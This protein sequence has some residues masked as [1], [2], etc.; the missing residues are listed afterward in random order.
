M[1][2]V[3]TSLRMVSIYPAGA[4]KPISI[5]RTEKAVSDA[6]RARVSEDV[7]AAA[8]LRELNMED[9]CDQLPSELAVPDVGGDGHR[10]S[11]ES[12][13][14]GLR[15]RRTMQVGLRKPCDF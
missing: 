4:E 9:E 6:A 10:S 3:V 2:A 13:R 7:K 12:R 8:A 5:L 15:R 1:A 11:L 14:S